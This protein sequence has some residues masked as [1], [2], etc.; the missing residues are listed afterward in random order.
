MWGTGD[1]FCG[2]YCV[3]QINVDLFIAICNNMPMQS[4]SA[5]STIRSFLSLWGRVP[6]CPSL[7]KD[8]NCGGGIEGRAS[9]RR[10]FGVACGRPQTSEQVEIGPF[11]GLSGWE[12][13]ERLS[14]LNR[15]CLNEGNKAGDSRSVETRSFGLSEKFGQPRQTEMTRTRGVR[16][17]PSSMTGSSLN[18]APAIC[19]SSHRVTIQHRS[20][21]PE[22]STSGVIPSGM[23]VR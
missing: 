21:T 9:L 3:Q 7:F 6:P 8:N 4:A 15:P 13:I 20:L 12:H 16:S 23:G 11:E 10:M 5:R 19:K 2:K 1:F 18:P 14:D 22:H 17:V